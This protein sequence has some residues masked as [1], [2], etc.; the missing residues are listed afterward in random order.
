LWREHGRHGCLARGLLQISFQHHRLLDETSLGF[1]IAQQV[2]HAA[3][4]EAL[5]GLN[6]ALEARQAVRDWAAKHADADGRLP[7]T[8][9]FAP[10]APP[11]RTSRDTLTEGITDFLRHCGYEPVARLD[12]NGE[13]TLTI[14]LVARTFDHIRYSTAYQSE[15][16]STETIR[17]LSGVRYTR[18]TTE[19]RI[20]T[21]HDSH[22][23]EQ[24]GTITLPSLS[25]RFGNETHILPPAM[26]VDQRS[27]DTALSHLPPATY[28]PAS[29]ATSVINL[30]YHCHDAALSPWRLG[31]PGAGEPDS[32][33]HLDDWEDVP[34]EIREWD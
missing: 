8:M 9:G 22:V 28:P 21:H 27:S 34:R 32:L 13:S 16:Q 29:D 10:T 4:T 30:Y 24:L 5:T 31:L 19:T 25:L 2:K 15:R 26:L 12:S 23:S 20:V 7:I 18:Q 1:V 3:P 33:L 17:R 6:A 14:D 11:Y